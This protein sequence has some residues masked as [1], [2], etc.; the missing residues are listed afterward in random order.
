MSL[1]LGI[2]KLFGVNNE[3]NF[4]I[5]SIIIIALFL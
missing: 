1:N 4:L 2:N 3:N 5:Y